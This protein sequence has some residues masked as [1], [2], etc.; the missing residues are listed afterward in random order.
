VLVVALLLDPAAVLAAPGRDVGK[1]SP[2]LRA[3]LY[4]LVSHRTIVPTQ[5]TGACGVADKFSGI[6]PILH[7]DFCI[8]A[9]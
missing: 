9:T 5:S 6:L 7:Y 3:L 4:F 1:T 2:A 8:R